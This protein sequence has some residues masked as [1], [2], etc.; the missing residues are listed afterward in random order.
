MHEHGTTTDLQAEEFLLA[1]RRRGYEVTSA[2]PGLSFQEGT[3]KQCFGARFGVFKLAA[4]GKTLL[5]GLR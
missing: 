1:Y 2:A 4:D 3:A 5:V